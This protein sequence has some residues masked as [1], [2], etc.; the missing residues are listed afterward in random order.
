MF[1]RRS[2][3][4]TAAAALAPQRLLAAREPGLQTP[5]ALPPS[6]Q[7]LTSLRERARPVSRDERRGRIDRARA[8]M[9]REK[10]SALVLC[11]GTSLVY[12]T[13]IRWG[14]AVIPQ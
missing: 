8:L 5:A 1:N 4:W 6:L 11:S 10:L 9:A 13:N 12:F 14:G 3:L 2:F 7:A